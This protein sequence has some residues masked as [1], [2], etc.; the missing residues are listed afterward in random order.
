MDYQLLIFMTNKWLKAVEVVSKDQYELINID[1][2]E[3]LEYHEEKGIRKFC[4]SLKEYYSID[5]F[6]DLEMEISLI[7]NEVSNQAI[8]QLVKQLEKADRKSVV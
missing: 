2:N 5:E 3:I 7:Y 8:T 1:G 6:S 4:N